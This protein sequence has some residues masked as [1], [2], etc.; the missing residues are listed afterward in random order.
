MVSFDHN[1][2]LPPATQIRVDILIG[3]AGV[4]AILLA[5]NA[6]LLYLLLLFVYMVWKK[7]GAGGEMGNGS[8]KCGCGKKG[9]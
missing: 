1:M 4:M 5:A 9:K 7:T 3:I 6:V 2:V 8:G